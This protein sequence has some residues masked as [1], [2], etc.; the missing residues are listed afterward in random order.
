[1]V[2][3]EPFLTPSGLA[4]HQYWR[5]VVDPVK[6]CW[7][8]FWQAIKNVFAKPI[9]CL[10]AVLSALVILAIAILLPRLSLISYIFSSDSF[11]LFEKWKLLFSLIGTLKSNFSNWS[12]LMLIVLAFF[13]GLNVALI[14]YYFKKRHDILKATGSGLGILAIISGVLGIGCASCGS[15][16]LTSVIGFT[17]AVSF[18]GVLPL[19]GLEFGLLAIILFIVSIFILSKKIV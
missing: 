17:A 13:T 12:L 2:Y 16:I 1:M 14:I 10:I 3:P 9:Y 6:S 8:Y 4:Q 7:I 19:K 5:W 18:L 15:V 11:G